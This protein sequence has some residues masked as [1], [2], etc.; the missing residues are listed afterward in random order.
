MNR[1]LSFLMASMFLA[2]AGHTTS[3]IAEQP[4]AAT[5]LI[6][7]M[8]TETDHL[9]LIMKDGKIYKNTIK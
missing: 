2:I 9:R 4:K 7:K 3:A 1:R 6:Q 8:V 5:T